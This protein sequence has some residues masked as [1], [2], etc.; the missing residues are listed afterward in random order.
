MAPCHYL[1]A[2]LCEVLGAR[3]Q[4]SGSRSFFQALAKRIIIESDQFRMSLAANHS[5]LSLWEWAPRSFRLALGA[6]LALVL[7]IVSGFL[8]NGAK[9]ETRTLK[10]YYTHTKESAT[11]TFKKNGKY[12]KSGLK[13][14]NHILRDFRRNEPTKMDP[15]LFDIVWEVYQK[16]GSRKPIHVISGYRSPR[17]NNMLRRR[18]RKVAKNSQH[19][20]G[21]ALDFFLPD[22]KV[23]KLRALGLQAHG[24]G[25]GYYR[26][27]FVHLD[28]GRVR[29]WPRMSRRQL[30]R[31]FPRGRTIHV[32]SDGRQLKGYK[33]AAANLK[34]GLNY[35]GTPR[36]T[37]ANSS[38]IARL[39]K[40]SGNDGDESEGT[41]VAAKLKAPPKK[42][43]A[44]P[45]AA[46]AKKPSGADPFALEVA[47][48]QKVQSEEI[49]KQS[50]DPA[51]TPEAQE[52]VEETVEIAQVTVPRR[53]PAANVLQVP[54][55]AAQEQTL[56]PISATEVALL[57]PAA[58]PVTAEPIA[59]ALQPVPQPQPE[60][61]RFSD[62]DT[63]AINN[64]KS[65]IRTALA[66]Q[67]QLTAAERAVEAQANV[68]LAAKLAGLQVP[69]PQGSETSST[70]FSTANTSTS[71]GFEVPTP[72]WRSQPQEAVSNDTQIAALPEPAPAT[73][74]AKAPS[75]PEQREVPEMVGELKLG[76]L[77]GTT[78]RAWAVATTTRVGPIAALSAPKYDQ[79][80]RRAAPLSVYSAGF[81]NNRPPLRADRFSGRALTRVAFA[82]FTN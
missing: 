40:T 16:S 14:L 6:L 61:S 48:A 58:E 7:V 30:S 38:L 44:K 8:S 15:E 22:V 66:R 81:A 49:R 33:I 69:K 39:F 28:T 3:P 52:V 4:G 13:K 2:I 18:G 47:A 42:R 78:V 46:V 41:R 53:R 27:S 5:K 12:V 57:Q 60:P 51:V 10:V 25:V 37:A 21:K 64:L 70:G 80:T 62:A 45:A 77:D 43:P 79:G 56:E 29:H 23:S 35:D 68:E 50:L 72:Q 31:V 36:R 63:A 74:P 54:V 59:A 24:G 32:P 11:I 71:G 75:E 73:V 55:P 9:A 20:R 67:R 1:T 82:Y 34:K 26:G 65:R 17:T 19:T 76:N